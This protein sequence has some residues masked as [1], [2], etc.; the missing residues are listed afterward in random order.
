MDSQLLRSLIPLLLA[1][2]ALGQ[3][4]PRIRFSRH[5]QFP[6]SVGNQWV[7]GQR[8]RAAGEPLTVQVAAANQ[9]HGLT[10]YQ[11]IGYAEGPAWVRY[12]AAGELVQYDPAGGPEKLWY[13]FFAPD[14]FSFRSQLAVACV[15]QAALRYRQGEIR[16]PAGTFSPHL[17]V[18][19]Q[20]GP[21][22][23]AG[24]SEE[25]FVSGVGMVRRTSLTIAG[26]RT[27]ELIWARVNGVVVSAPELSFQLAIDR[28][29]YYADFM[30][31]VDPVRSVPVL[32]ARLTLRNTSSLPVTLQ[33]N[34]GQQYDLVIRDAAG[35]QVYQWSQGRAFTLVLS[36]LE[37]K[38]GERMFVEEIRL[39]DRAGRTLPPGPYTLEAWLTTSAG[40]VYAATVPLEIQ[41]TF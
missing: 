17:A 3:A 11:L 2:A 16:V 35:Q 13:P 26:P 41:Y 8:G 23:D 1:G 40:K 30:P 19:Y 36:R 7:Y 6:L 22:A 25:V 33:F 9:F 32:T 18:E 5:P 31:P 27:A 24:F 20:P 15:Q 37:L 38:E 10:Y 12:N 4:P 28:P 34:S 14:G 29:L 39:A 21:C